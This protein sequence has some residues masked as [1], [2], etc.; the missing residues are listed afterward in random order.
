MQVVFLG[1]GTL[2][3][4]ADRASTSLVVRSGAQALWIDCGRNSLS[5]A[6]ECGFD[7]LG[8]PELLLTHLHPDHSCELVSLLF[9]RN[10]H[11]DERGAEVL[12]APLRLTG[13]RG[14]AHAVDAMGEVW[15]W[16]RPRF[17]FE[18]EEIDGGWKGVRA[19]F[20]IEAF[21]VPHG[22][23]PALGYR[24]GREGHEVAFTGDSGPGAALDRLAA[25]VDLLVAECGQR[26]EEPTER[27]LGPE[28]AAEVA[29]RAGCSALAL[30]H[31][32]PETDRSQALSRARSRF[33]RPTLLAE[34]GMI[35]ELSAEG[36][37]EVG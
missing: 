27:H 23:I 20:E 33:D 14:T 34:D 5:R 16:V 28:D 36:M 7:P 29:R 9:A 37:H 3:P 2:E 11:R 22:E 15:R 1:T 35:L 31:L 25:G 13:P 30:T 21:A 6:V 4:Q 10:Y 24:I 8:A 17:P 18:V 12:G 19:G 26:G 32:Y